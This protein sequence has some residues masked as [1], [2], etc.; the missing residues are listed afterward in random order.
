MIFLFIATKCEFLFILSSALLY[1]VAWLYY[2]HVIKPVKDEQTS[3]NIQD[4]EASKI[5]GNSQAVYQAAVIEECPD[6]E[7]SK[8]RVYSCCTGEHVD[9]DYQLCPVC[10]EH[11]CEEECE[12]CYGKGIIEIY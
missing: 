6:C 2:Q 11:L 10:M 8:V 4:A 12:T 9:N 1:W 7:G 3:D 5:L